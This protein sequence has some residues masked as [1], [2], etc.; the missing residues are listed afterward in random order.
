MKNKFN[1]SVL[2]PAF[3]YLNGVKKILLKSDILKHDSMKF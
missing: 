1:I 2:I 3:N